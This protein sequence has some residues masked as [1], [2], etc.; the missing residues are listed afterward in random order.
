MIVRNECCCRRRSE[1]AG[2]D[3]SSVDDCV[4]GDGDGQSFLELGRSR[5][6][7]GDDDEKESNP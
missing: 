5:V 4:G 6:C 7:D 1:Q 3:H 2:I